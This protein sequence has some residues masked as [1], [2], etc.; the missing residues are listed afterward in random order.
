MVEAALWLFSIFDGSLDFLSL[1]VAG[2]FIYFYLFQIPII[3]ISAGRTVAAE[4]VTASAATVLP[5]VKQIGCVFGPL[6]M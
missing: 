2:G 4:A 3:P 6:K 1:F 5:G